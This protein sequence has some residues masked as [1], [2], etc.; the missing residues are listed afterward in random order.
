MHMA[1]GLD[2]GDVILARSFPLRRRE[3][4]GSLSDR[5]AELAPSALEEAMSMLSGGN[6]PRIV[7]DESLATV[8][9]KI[10]REATLLDWKRPAV[11]LE[12]KIRS[13]QPRPAAYGILPIGEGGMP[14]K[15]HSAIVARRASGVP[16]SILRVDSRGI[17]VACGVGGL[18][19]GRIQPEGG[20]PMPSAAFARGRSLPVPR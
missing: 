16:G 15:I 4:A 12:R 1:E 9:G 19:L 20:K 5:L 10:T 2:T 18:L 14:V 3:T 11:E 7:Q 6:A 8:T 17:L 13:L